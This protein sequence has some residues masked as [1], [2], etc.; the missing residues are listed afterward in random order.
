M[1][2]TWEGMILT[3]YN[4]ELQGALPMGQRALGPS[5]GTDTLVRQLTVTHL[6]IKYHPRGLF[7]CAQLGLCPPGL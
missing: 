2:E 5:S 1:E 4:V 3:V 7:S 6:Q